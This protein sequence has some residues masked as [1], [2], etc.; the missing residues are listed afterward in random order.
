M[1]TDTLE[2]LQRL[3]TYNSVDVNQRCGDRHETA[4]HLA[5][6]IGS[7]N[8]IKALIDAGAHVNARTTHN[9]NALWLAAWKQQ[10]QVRPIQVFIY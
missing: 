2:L 5:A 3:L 9:E 1:A 6:V 7:V 4:L 8:A 10:T